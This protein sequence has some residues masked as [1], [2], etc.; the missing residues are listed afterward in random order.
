VRPTADTLSYLPFAA[1]RLAQVR[2]ADSIQTVDPSAEP[3][4][5]GTFFRG[6]QRGIARSTGDAEQ[7]EW[8][9]IQFF[10]PPSADATTHAWVGAGYPL[11]TA[12][13]DTAAMRR[14][15]ERTSEEPEAISIRIVCNDEAMIDETAGDLYGLRDLVEFDISVEHGLTREEFHDLLRRETDFLHYIGHVDEDG[16]VCADGSL[17][18]RTVETTGVRAFLLNACHS[19]QQGE[20]LVHAGADGGIVTLS[21][22]YNEQA[23][24]MGQLTARLLNQ[25]FPLDATMNVLSYGPLSSHRYAAVGDHQTQVC[26]PS[27]TGPSFI[28][29]KQ[30]GAEVRCQFREYPTAS[31]CLGTVTQQHLSGSTRWSLL[32]K[33]HEF[34]TSKE[35][36]KSRVQ[37]DATPVISDS[38]V[39]WGLQGS[40]LDQ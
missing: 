19:Y 11:G 10:D 22:V 4:Q 1:N 34:T 13:V 29:L 8:E 31:R 35:E 40:D 2:I 33:A 14:R 24:K 27:D 16:V 9:D 23:T 38:G 39:C 12:K 28:Y 32:G 25:G 5:L 3:T 15:L 18:L 26:Q 36:I 37:L 6:E 17:D 7:A 21:R 20:A 30:T